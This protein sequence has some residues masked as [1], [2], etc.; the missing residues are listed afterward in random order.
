MDNRR[1]RGF[2]AR[3]STERAKSWAPP[4]LLPTPTEQPGWRFRWIR[5]SLLGAADP[6]NVSSRFRE[7][8]E[9]VKLVDHPELKLSGNVN[10]ND[11]DNVEIGGLTL[12]KIPEEMVVQRNAYYSNV[13]RQQMDSVEQSY[14]RENDRRMAKFSE[15]N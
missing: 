4:S 5:T 9:P 8:W 10:G 7:G 14:M 15:R 1:P 2:E 11:G 12:C 6:K 13:N 3:E